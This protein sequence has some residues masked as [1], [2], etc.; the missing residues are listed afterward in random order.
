MATH[1]SVLAWSITWTE[2]PGGLQSM[3]SQR[4][5]HNGATKHM[6]FCKEGRKKAKWSKVLGEQGQE[7]S[8]PMIIIADCCCYWFFNSSDTFFS[9]CLPPLP[10]PG[11]WLT[12]CL[13]V[14]FC[15]SHTEAAGSSEPREKKIQGRVLELCVDLP[16]WLHMSHRARGFARETQG[17]M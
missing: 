6:S 11:C 17:C 12:V 8:S 5:R 13:F 4:V 14:W 1:S 10:S 2:E 16:S 7:E 9:I 15:F 3:G